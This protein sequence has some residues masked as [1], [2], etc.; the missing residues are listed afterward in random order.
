M[1]STQEEED[2]KVRK[3]VR[4]FVNVEKPGMTTG[5]DAL[6]EIYETYEEVKET[7]DKQ[8]PDEDAK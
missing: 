5:N 2:L 3:L 1:S 8:T 6:I 4:T 7:E